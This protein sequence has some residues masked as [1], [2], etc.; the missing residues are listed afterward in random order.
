MRRQAHPGSSFSQHHY[1]SKGFQTETVTWEVG[2]RRGDAWCVRA[3][4]SV[5]PE[6]PPAG[7]RCAP[8]E[9]THSTAAPVSGLFIG[10]CKLGRVK[11]P[12]SRSPPALPNKFTH[13]SGGR[14]RCSLIIEPAQVTPQLT[15]FW[16]R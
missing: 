1:I 9:E 5:W 12:R 2:K 14:R 4:R 6:Q 11:Q 3:E 10:T 8:R 7:V 13:G 16:G 15:Q